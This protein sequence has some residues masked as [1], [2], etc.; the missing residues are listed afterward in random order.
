M[1]QDKGPLDREWEAAVSVGALSSLEERDAFYLGA[2]ACLKLVT[3][4]YPD[5]DA[6][7]KMVLDIAQNIVKIM[8]ELMERR[9]DIQS[10]TN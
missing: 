6:G 2:S 1:E 4:T 7:A 9:R 3:E 8:D 10:R 5:R